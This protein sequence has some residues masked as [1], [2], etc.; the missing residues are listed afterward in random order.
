M[1]GVIALLLIGIIVILGTI[2]LDTEARATR[3]ERRVAK[4]QCLEQL[5]RDILRSQE[6]S[7]NLL[8]S[9]RMLANENGILCEREAAHLQVIAGVEEENTRLGVSLDESI[10]RLQEYEEQVNDLIDEAERSAWR[11]SQLEETIETLEDALAAL[12][13]K[14]EPEPEPATTE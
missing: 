13:P 14:T 10:V 8:E 7:S 4:V 6:Y 11:I 3:W 1:R 5:N 9:V 12:E 2:A